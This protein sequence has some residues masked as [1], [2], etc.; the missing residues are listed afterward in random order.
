MA[1]IDDKDGFTQLNKLNIKEYLYI[2]EQ[3]INSLL[4]NVGNT[5]LFVGTSITQLNDD[6]LSDFSQISHSSDG[7]LRWAQKE[8]EYGF[9]CPVWIDST[10]VKG[11]EENDSTARGFWGLNAGVA[12]QS[13]EQIWNRREKIAKINATYIAIEAGTNDILDIGVSKERIHQRRKDLVDYFTE[14]NYKVIL[15]PILARETTSWS[16]QE[17]R[18]KAQWV[19]NATISEL[20]NLA[21]VYYYN[22][23]D[24]WVDWS[25]ANGEPVLGYTDDGVHPNTI[26]GY[27][28]GIKFGQW[29]KTFLPPRSSFLSSPNNIYSSTNDRGNAFL[30]PLLAGVG[31][32]VTNAT[33]VAPD[34]CRIQRDSGASVVVGSKE[35]NPNGIGDRAVIDIT[36]PGTSGTGSVFFGSEFSNFSHSLGGEWVQASCRI[37]LNTANNSLNK[38]YLLCADTSGSTLITT[39]IDGT[40]SSGTYPNSTFNYLFKTPPFLMR[41]ESSTCRLRVYIVVDESESNAVQVKISEIGFNKV[42]DP[43]IVFNTTP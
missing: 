32:T 21:N 19:N 22:L 3:P 35:V 15:F 23:N 28:F 18:D 25:N 41:E 24:G 5:I 39:S 8:C 30:N 10:N 16:T 13:I 2:K 40:N 34:D 37:N 12:G 20:A 11:W 42:D 1:E 33:G 38:I 7:F 31:G 17:Q 4:S 27:S 29:L 26:G 6:V 9:E 36:P 43:R 14:Q